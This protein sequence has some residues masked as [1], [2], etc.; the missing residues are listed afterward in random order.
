MQL[1]AVLF[2][3]GDT[4]WHAAQP[5]P[6]AEFRRMAAERAG[7]FLRH[8]GTPCRDPEQLARVAWASME[9]AMRAARSSDCVEP[10]YAAIARSAAAGEGVLL[11]H[12]QAA[13]LMDAIYISGAEGGKLAYPDARHTLLELRNRGFR[14]GIVTNRAFGGERFRTDLREL[15]LDVGWDAVSVS[16]EVGFLKPHPAL[17]E[18]ALTALGLEPRQAL[19]VGNSLVEDVSGAQALGIAAA[20]KRSQPDADGVTPDLTFDEVSDLLRWPP[21]K[22]AAH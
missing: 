2:D 3:V 14:L 7:A 11:T 18:H 16:V 17:F 20:W 4:L 1:R 15:G 21:L 5:P 8:I 6:P 13:A 19:M 12:A 22:E 9:G 10:D